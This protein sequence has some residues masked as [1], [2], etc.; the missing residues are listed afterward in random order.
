MEDT[1][2][3]YRLEKQGEKVVGTVKELTVND[4]P[5]GEVLIRV[6]YS[7]VNYK[8]AMAN[9]T[10]SPIV[11][12][13]PFTPGIDLAGVVVESADDRFTEGDE[14]IVTSYE[15]GVS[16]DGGYSEYQR[17]NA[18][19]VV[20][21]PK[22]LSLKHAMLLGTAGLTA[23]LSV[24]QLERSALNKRRPVL[25]T[26]ASGGVASISI[27]I[28]SK[29][30]YTVEASTGK[31]QLTDQ[32]KQLG[33]NTV[34]TREDV[35]GDKPRAIDR[36]TYAGAVDVVGGDTLA[37][38]LAK[39]DYNGAVALSGLTGGVK[40][41]TTVYPFILRGAKLLGIDSVYTP[42][43]K[44]KD[45]WHQLANAYRLTDEQFDLIEYKTIRLEDL[46]TAL[47]EILAGK[48]QGRYLVELI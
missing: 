37:Q 44:R 7:G 39:L 15:L 26:G 4:L 14:V 42:M 3:A 29:L 27:A 33:A 45:M 9:M 12:S 16:H 48:A 31:T 38:V 47:P 22:A 43:D 30:G 20:R 28:L 19:W 21:K 17:V 8:D 24:D 25:V 36:P 5:E 46:A 2:K 18:A 11:K 41:P 34:I 1:F 32:L 10:G 35:L 40:I 23:A 6:H 13:Y